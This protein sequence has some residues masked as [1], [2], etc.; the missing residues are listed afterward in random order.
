MRPL[1]YDLVER[2]LIRKPDRYFEEWEPDQGGT[3]APE[4]HTFTYATAIKIGTRI[5]HIRY[6][7]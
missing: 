4:N 7:A 1:S 3:H 5:K 2:Y 6:Y